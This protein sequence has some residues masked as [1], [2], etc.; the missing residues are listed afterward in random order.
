MRAHACCRLDPRE[1]RPAPRGPAILRGD[2]QYFDDLAPTGTL[3]V[4][5]VRSTI[6]H[7]KLEGVDTSDAESMPGVVA[8][9]TADDLDLADVHG[10]MMLPPTL[11]R[12][13]LARGVVRFV[14]DIVAVVVAETAGAGRRRRRSGDRRLR[15]AARGRRSRSRARRR[16]ARRVRGAR[17]EPRHR[18]RLRRRSDDR[19]RR[20]RRRRV[21][22]RI[23]NQR[24]APVP[25]EPNGIA[26]RA[27][28]AR[29]RLTF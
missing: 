21:E 13:P 22:G 4:A 12:P 26:R 19:A 10:F 5:F 6:A 24:L 3:H 20:R 2:A 9:Y 1:L 15:P 28:R 27:R 18:V 7:A 11:N 17:L 8:V 23:V 29:R 14:G 16:R 25:M